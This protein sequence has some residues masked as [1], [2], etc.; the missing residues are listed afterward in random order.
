MVK[1]NWF[2][3]VTMPAIVIKECNG[4]LTIQRQFSYNDYQKAFHNS[5]LQKPSCGN[6][7]EGDN[8]K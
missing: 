3:G 2:N 7:N 4:A 1:K 5:N 8:L 6:I